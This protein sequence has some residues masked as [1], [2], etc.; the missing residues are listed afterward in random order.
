MTSS[1]LK[2][3]RL[4]RTPAIRSLLQE[5]HV[6]LDS[7][8]YPLFIKEGLAEKVPIQSMPGQYQ[9]GLSDLEQEI[10]E[11]SQ[12]GLKAVLLFGIPAFKDELGSAA[13]DLEGIIP[14]AINQIR[15]INPNL[16][17]IADLCFCEYTSHGH[18]GMLHQQALDTVLL[19][20]HL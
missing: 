8:I 5:N 19:G 10:K 12:L 14:Q 9:L 18:C 2:L 11:I 6:R 3:T 4:R 1:T 17:I 16:L 13:F 7:L 15:S 20:Q